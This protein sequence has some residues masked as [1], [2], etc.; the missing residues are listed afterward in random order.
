MYGHSSSGSLVMPEIDRS[1]NRQPFGETAREWKRKLT[2]LF[3]GNAFGH[4]TSGRT[5][6]MFRANGG[7]G[8]PCGRDPGST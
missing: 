3:R 8:K 6:Y 2:K 5:D 7:G 4:W 1:E